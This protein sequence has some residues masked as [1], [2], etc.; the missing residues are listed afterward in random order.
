[1]G[2][3]SARALG[4]SSI[5]LHNFSAYSLSSSLQHGR[6][7]E[8]AVQEHSVCHV[9]AYLIPPRDG[10][11]QLYRSWEMMSSWTA[12]TCAAAGLSAK[13]ALLLLLSTT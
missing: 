9:M 12:R 8:Q 2:T 4:A 6:G 3:P 1:M 13:Q 11:W 7:D 5:I 10:R